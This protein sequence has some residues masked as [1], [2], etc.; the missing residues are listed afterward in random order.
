MADKP[1]RSRPYNEGEK[2]KQ[3]A[4]ESSEL[5]QVIA[6]HNSSYSVDD[7]LNVAMLYVTEGNM[8][9]VSSMTEIPYVTLDSWKR[10]NWWPEALKFCHKRKDQELEQ[11]FSKVIHDTVNEIHDRVINGDWKLDKS[12]DKIRIPISGRDLSTII[13]TIH[14]KRQLLR[15]EATSLV[16]QKDSQTDKL[17]AL[18]QKFQE[19]SNHL[20]SK[21]IEGEIVA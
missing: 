5:Y 2:K 17:R 9:K 15:G 6:N 1:S 12:G 7:R 16:V 19:F 18:E 14:D 11:K 3:L 10:T 21:T 13:S 8:K 20:K 4:K